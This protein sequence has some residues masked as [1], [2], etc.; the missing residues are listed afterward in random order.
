VGPGYWPA[1]EASAAGEV[2]RMSE[3]ARHVL[4]VSGVVS[5]GDGRILLIKTEKAGWELPGGQVEHGEDFLAAL[6]REVWEETG[7]EVAV[8]RLSGVTSSV[9]ARPVTILTFVCRHTGGDPRPGDDSLEAGWFAPD[10]ALGLITH[11]VEQVRLKDALGKG[12]GVR[13]RAYRCLAVDGQQRDG[14]EIVRFHRC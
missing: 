5:D 8:G 7:C 10:T 9:V 3:D 1:E 2:R 4:G 12:P 13:Y 11:P 6:Q 14:Y